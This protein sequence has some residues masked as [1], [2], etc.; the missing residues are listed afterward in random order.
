MSLRYFFFGYH[1]FIFLD[2]FAEWDYC[3]ICHLP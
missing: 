3:L 2:I 1:D